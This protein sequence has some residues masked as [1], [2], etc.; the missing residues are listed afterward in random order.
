M[1]LQV[2]WGG[3]SRNQQGGANNVIQVDGDL[4]M[5]P[6]CQLSYGR[7]SVKKLPPGR[8]LSFQLSSDAWQFSSL[9]IVSGDFQATAHCWISEPVSLSK[10]VNGPFN[11]NVWD[12]R[13][14]LSHSAAILAGFHSHKSWGLLFPAMESRAGDPGLRPFVSQGRPCLAFLSLFFLEFLLTFH[15]YSYMFSTFCIRALNYI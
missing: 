2:G 4:Y 5:T 1:G 14:P 6:V 10:S 9:L 8:K 13:S 7:T 12:S 3:V 15:I 11:E